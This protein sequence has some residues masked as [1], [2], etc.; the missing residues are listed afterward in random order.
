MGLGRAAVGYFERA[1]AA[2]GDAKATCNGIT[3]QFA[4]EF[5]ATPLDSFPVSAERFGGLIAARQR[6]GLNPRQAA[7]V[8]AKMASE[9]LDADAAIAALD[10]TV[11]SDD[12]AV[13]EAVRRA[14]AANPKAVADYRKGKTAAANSLKGAVMK[15][16][17]GAGRADVVDRVLKE[18]L[19]RE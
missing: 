2:S 4:A 10:I 19:G 18:E 15:D 6:L 14:M 5:K 9:P 3:N 13:V 7:D 8:F 16:L 1:A 11:V 17:R 12:A